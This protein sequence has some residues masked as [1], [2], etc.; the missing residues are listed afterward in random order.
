MEQMKKLCSLLGKEAA[1]KVLRALDKEKHYTAS[2]VA[3]R[4]GIHIATAVKY[5]ALL[6]EIDILERQLRKTK[7]RAVYE[8]W[9]KSDTIKIEF[10]LSSIQERGEWD[11]LFSLYTTIRSLYGSPLPEDIPLLNYL[12]MGREEGMERMKDEEIENVNRRMAMAYM[13][14]L[15][16]AEENFGE[17][18]TEMIRKKVTEEKI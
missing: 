7:R 13:R 2:E 4:A 10:H 3:E 5:L 8:Y 15:D 11:T 1:F 9:L 12:Q 6:Y 17:R 14:L 18:T 16:F